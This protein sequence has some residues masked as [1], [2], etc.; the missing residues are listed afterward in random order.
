MFLPRFGSILSFSPF[1]VVQVTASILQQR[2][3]EMP[4]HT[5][6]AIQDSV[7]GVKADSAC[8]SIATTIP[9]ADSPAEILSTD[10]QTLS[11]SLHGT[12]SKLP[13]GQ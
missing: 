1:Q 2:L 6:S 13:P 4:S 11:L 8:S 3:P 10:G 9:Q 5:S 12:N 7:A